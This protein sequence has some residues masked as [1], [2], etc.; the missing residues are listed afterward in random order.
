MLPART[1]KRRNWHKKRRGIKT[2]PEAANKIKDA[3]SLKAMI[4]KNKK[5]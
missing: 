1:R 5:K 4:K 3:L 2:T